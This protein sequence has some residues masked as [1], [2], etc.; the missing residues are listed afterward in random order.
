MNPRPRALDLFC[1]AGGASMGLHRAGFDV[2]G[3]DIR[4]QPRYP[5]KFIKAD[6]LKP[7]VDLAEFN[8][9]WASPPCQAHT[10][11]KGM[12]NAKK[13]HD[14]I[15][16]TRALLNASGKFW[17]MENVPGAPLEFS[18][19]LCGTMFGLGSGDAELRRHRLFETSAPLLAPQ[20]AHSKPRVIGVYGGHGRDR[21]RT[22]NTQDFPVSARMEAMGIDWMTGDELSQAI[23]PAYSEFIGREALRQLAMAA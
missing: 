11:L 13:H 6:T 5:F 7:P 4:P 2:T 23:P 18:I 15:P 8:L 16:P 20:C 22:V 14:L 1:G 10:A 17:V 21:R 12:W 3:V 19:V 9:I